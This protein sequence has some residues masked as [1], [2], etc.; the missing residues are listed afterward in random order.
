MKYGRVLLASAALVALPAVSIG[1]SGA[2]HAP[3]STAD[4]KSKAPVG[5]ATHGV[6]KLA[7][8]A[9]GEVPLR[10]DQRTAIEKLATDVDAAHVRTA[11]GRRELM[12]AL[13]DQIEAGTIDPAALQPKLERVGAESTT[14]RKADADALDRLHAI[15]DTEQR[16]A[17]VTALRARMKGKQG[18]A[19]G[20]HF[21]NLRHLM[22]ELQLSEEQ[23]TKIHEAL[24]GAHHEG[25]GQ[26]AAATGGRPEHRRGGKHG[27]GHGKHHGGSAF[28]SF[29]GDDFDANAMLARGGQARAAMGGRFVH[30]AEA[31]VPILTPAQRKIVADKLRASAAGREP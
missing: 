9:L 29:R 7:G 27:R 20:E 15:L 23:R 16:D 5:V 10:S 4:A 2:E 1:C 28:E 8:D 3:Q 12:N 14:A 26:D 18:G 21:G 13:A 6:V 24:R 11:D 31:I 19:H 17:F 22:D 25:Q 30:L